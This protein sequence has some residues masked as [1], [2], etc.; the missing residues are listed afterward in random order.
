MNGGD[1]NFRKKKRG[2]LG[3]GSR[4]RIQVKKQF[5]RYEARSKQPV[6]R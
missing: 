4:A 6:I 2:I 1:D 5:S 3:D